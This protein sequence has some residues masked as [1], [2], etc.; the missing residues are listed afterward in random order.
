MRGKEGR[1]RE[2]KKENEREGGEKEGGRCRN[3]NLLY[4]VKGTSVCL[5]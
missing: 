2:G 3:I 4:P 5:G 1:R